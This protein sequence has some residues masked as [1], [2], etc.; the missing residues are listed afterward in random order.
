MIRRPLR[1]VVALK[2][3]VQPVFLVGLGL[4]LTGCGSGPEARYDEVTLV[5]AAGVVTLDSQPL[6]QAVV[7]FEDPA[8][9]TFSFGVTDADGSYRLQFDSVKSGVTPG[10]KTVR[11][12]TSRRIEGLTLQE[13]S[14]ETGTE[15]PTAG[16]SPERVPARYNTRSELSVEVTSGES[17]YNFE[18]KSK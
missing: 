4:A 10:P 13:E 1:D 2:C 12:S 14:G 11:I 3:R 15:N 17:E 5:S 6:A 16:K 18:L 8:N 7:T 9:G